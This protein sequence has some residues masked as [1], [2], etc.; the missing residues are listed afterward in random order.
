MLLT[1]HLALLLTDNEDRA[2]FRY[3]GLKWLREAVSTTDPGIPA[4]RNNIVSVKY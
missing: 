2:I 4:G 3:S 1:E